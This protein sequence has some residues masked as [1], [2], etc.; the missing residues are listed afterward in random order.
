MTQSSSVMLS[1][2]TSGTVRNNESS[3]RCTQCA[4]MSDCTQSPESR[5]RW[6]WYCPLRPAALVRADCAICHRLHSQI[7][8]L[9]RDTEIHCY[10][11]MCKA[12]Q[13]W[14]QK[15]PYGNYCRLLWVAE[16]RRCVFVPVWVEEESKSKWY[17]QCSQCHTYIEGCNVH[18]WLVC[19]LFYMVEW[20]IV[21]PLRCPK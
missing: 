6:G 19:E 2:N 4:T 11:H 3:V 12:I 14:M 15:G 8:S 1:C 18:S 17:L 9:M 20:F 5:R 21:S 10:G 7:L 13:P 16:S